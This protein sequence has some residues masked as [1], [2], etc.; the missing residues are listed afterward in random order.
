MIWLKNCLLGIEQ[1]WLTSRYIKD[2]FTVPYIIGSGS[3]SGNV[4]TSENIDV[5]VYLED[6]NAHTYILK[7]M[8]YEFYEVSILK[9]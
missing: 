3:C 4:S 9:K 1:Q 2:S 7:K 8:N 5:L 6:R